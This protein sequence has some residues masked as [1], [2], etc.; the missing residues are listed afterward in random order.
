MVKRTILSPTPQRLV[1]ERL[2]TLARA[3]KDQTTVPTGIKDLGSHGNIIWGRPDG[4]PVTIREVDADLA[5]AQERI[6]AAESELVDSGIRLGEAEQAVADAAATIDGKV[7]DVDLDDPD[8]AER[9]A[10]AMSLATK[11]LI[12]TEEAVLNHATLIG[13]TVVDD[14]NVN[15]TLI[16]QDGVFTG[17][18]DF[19]NVNVTGEAIIDK[20][21]ATGISASL[22]E[23]G[24]FVGESFEGGSFTGGLF[25]TSDALPGQVE[26]ADNGY[27]THLDG[28]GAFPGLRIT[29]IDTSDMEYPAGIGPSTH[30][31]TVYGGQSKSGGSSIVQANPNGSFLRT[32][33][34]EGGNGGEIQTTTTSAFMRTYYENG[35][36]ASVIQSSR[37]AAIMRTY[38]TDGSPAG[39]IQATGTSCLMRTSTPGGGRGYIQ[40]E[41]TNA[42]QSV[43]DDSGALVASLSADPTETFLFTA[44]GGVKRYLTVDANGIWARETGWD[45]IDLTAAYRSPWVALSYPSGYTHPHGA[46]LAYCKIGKRIYWRGRFAKTD[47]STI[48]GGTA[49]SLLTLN[50]DWRPD[51]TTGLMT[52]A[53]GTR[54]ARIEVSAGSG[55]ISARPDTDTTWVSIDGL[56]YDLP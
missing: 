20:L 48:A 35:T 19:A 30:G 14:I 21:A 4:S 36:G 37:E 46:P 18:V 42:T 2:G 24:S 25:K 12:V 32:F 7:D 9:V 29:P 51:N 43:K 26:L 3:A 22:V 53:Q 54:V 56:W 31:L 11:K 5:E 33:R 17:T 49:T 13:Q 45:D 8:T 44:A 55:V 15:G 6:D 28:G 1:Q 27:I 23:G 47:G 50:G 52:P 40:V 41:G 38:R 34:P 39:D 10:T 16:G